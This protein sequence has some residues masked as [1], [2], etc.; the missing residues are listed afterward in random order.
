MP[1]S[2]PDFYQVPSR[3]LIGG[4]FVSAHTLLIAIQATS[5][6]LEQEF[7]LSSWDTDYPISTA[8]ESKYELKSESTIEISTCERD[9]KVQTQ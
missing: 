9:Q 1:L 4:F 8:H 7:L 2:F 5:Q 6:L 3:W